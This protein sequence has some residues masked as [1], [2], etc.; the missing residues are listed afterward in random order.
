MGPPDQA[1]RSC[2]EGPRDDLAAD[3]HFLRIGAF[4]A[5]VQET[6]GRWKPCTSKKYCPQFG[7]HLALITHSWS[8]ESPTTSNQHRGLQQQ[9]QGRLCHQNK[10]GKF[11]EP[12]TQRL[13]P[14]VVDYW[15]AVTFSCHPGSKPARTHFLKRQTYKLSVGILADLW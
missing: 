8:R 11:L 10:K 15:V 3:G 13:C 14:L 9:V 4:L 7:Q 6:L 2:Q 12:R 5:R 1:S